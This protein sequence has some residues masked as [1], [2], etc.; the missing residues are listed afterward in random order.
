MA[1]YPTSSHKKPRGA[2]RRYVV[3]YQEDCPEGEVI[4]FSVFANLA[5]EATAKTIDFIKSEN[6]HD[7]YFGYTLYPVLSD[8]DTDHEIY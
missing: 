2:P 1:N 5:S 8:E 3:T 4:T 6:L 7:S